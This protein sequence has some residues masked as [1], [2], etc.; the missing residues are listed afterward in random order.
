MMEFLLGILCFWLGIKLFGL[1]LRMAWGA[2]KIFVWLLMLAALPL[3]FFGFLFAGGLLLLL[4][5]ALLG[6]AFAV[7]KAVF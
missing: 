7:A 5:L 2:A 4:P 6:I 3:A 1:T